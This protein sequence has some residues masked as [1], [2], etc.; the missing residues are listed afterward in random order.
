MVRPLRIEYPGAWY[1]VACRGNRRSRIFGDDKDRL[2]FLKT[3]KESVEAFNVE[4][5]GYVLLDNHFHFLLRTP[6]A[7]LGRFPSK[8]RLKPD[9]RPDLRHAA[10]QHRLH[11]LL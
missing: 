5:H 1:H 3:L 6:E 4:M 9:L 8:V 10:L 7:N 2:R 11:H